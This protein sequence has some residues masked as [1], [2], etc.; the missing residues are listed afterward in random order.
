MIPDTNRLLFWIENREKIERPIYARA[1]ICG[2][3]DVIADRN[4][5]RLDESLDYC[6]WVLS[7]LDQ[8]REEDFGNGD[9]SRANPL[10]A[11]SRR[12][13]VDLIDTCIEKNVNVPNTYQHQLIY[14]RAEY[15][16]HTI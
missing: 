6:K 4:F 11:S 13:V 8:E 10:W 16:L 12:A 3:K 9:K 7:H 14:L 5:E 2:M 15:D 1:T